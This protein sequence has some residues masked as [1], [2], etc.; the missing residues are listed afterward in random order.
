MVE[1]GQRVA[2]FFEDRVAQERRET[3]LGNPHGLAGGVHV[4]HADD[5]G[6]AFF[7]FIGSLQQAGVHG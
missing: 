7:G 1:A 3:G 6:V 4:D 5:R 2:S